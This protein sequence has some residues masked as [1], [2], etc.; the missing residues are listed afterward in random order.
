MRSACAISGFN[1]LTGLNMPNAALMFVGLDDW[2]KRQAPELHAAAI[3]RD[4]ESEI[5]RVS[6]GAHYRLRSA[7]AAWLRKRF[8]VYLATAESLRRLG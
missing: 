5:L 4:V 2:K 7:G 3:A 1:I 6:R 8:R